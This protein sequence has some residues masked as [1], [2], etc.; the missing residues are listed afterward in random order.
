MSVG[1]NL[2]PEM[3][4]HVEKVAKKIKDF[5]EQMEKAKPDGY[6]NVMNVLKNVEDKLTAYK[7][8]ISKNND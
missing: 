3:K 8:S 5:N 4:D 2:P 1:D 6:T 7:D